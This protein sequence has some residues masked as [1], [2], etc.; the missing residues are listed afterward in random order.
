MGFVSR[1]SGNKPNIKF[2]LLVV[3]EILNDFEVRLSKFKEFAMNKIN[4][5]LA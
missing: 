1:Y 4:S 5:I 2:Y 3:W